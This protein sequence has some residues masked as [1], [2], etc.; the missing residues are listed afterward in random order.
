MNEEKLWCR[1]HQR[2]SRR[3]I[4][5]ITSSCS[6]PWIDCS[7]P[8]GNHIYIDSSCP[9]LVQDG[10]RRAFC[11]GGQVSTSDVEAAINAVELRPHGSEAGDNDDRDRECTP[12]RNLTRLALVRT[13]QAKI[14]QP[15]PAEFD[16][17]RKRLSMDFAVAS[18]CLYNTL[19][20]EAEK[21]ESVPQGDPSIPVD[22]KQETMPVEV[23]EK[24]APRPHWISV[25]L[26]LLSPAFAAVALFISLESLEISRTSLDNARKAMEIGQ[27][28]YLIGQMRLT[29][30]HWESSPDGKHQIGT[31]QFS[32]VVINAGNTPATHAAFDFDAPEDA[33]IT[34]IPS[35]KEF[36]LGARQS[37]TYTFTVN[38][39]VASNPNVSLRPLQEF[40]F[41]VSL[42]Y[43]DAFG[44][45]QRSDDVCQST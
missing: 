34:Y 12:G 15:V 18:C 44:H 22:V 29:S 27:R 26:G 20:M 39:R 43:E 45:K 3:L 32:L 28:A 24:V 8:T 11:S 30:P 36:Q 5:M 9:P 38:R 37:R 4:R 6:D 40:T 10:L 35:D 41:C 33:R 1:L 14:P 2:S 19:P 13:R 42:N 17:L 7:R 16:F 23:H 31:I 25:G 21:N